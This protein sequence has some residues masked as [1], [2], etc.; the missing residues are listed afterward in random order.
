MKITLWVRVFDHIFKYK[1]KLLL[2]SNYSDGKELNSKDALF[3]KLLEVFNDE[4]LSFPK[5]SVDSG[6]NYFVQV[7]M[8]ILKRNDI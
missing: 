4:G 3:N 5:D 2:I 1:I 8:L 6:G 7:C